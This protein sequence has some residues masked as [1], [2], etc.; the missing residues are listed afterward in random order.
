MAAIRD[1]G[2]VDSLVGSFLINQSGDRDHAIRRES[3][4]LNGPVMS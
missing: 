4:P 3:P 1:K 2:V